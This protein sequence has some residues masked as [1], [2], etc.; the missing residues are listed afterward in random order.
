MGLFDANILLILTHT[1]ESG[2][3]LSRE[4]NDLEFKQS[5]GKKNWSRY[6]RTM[7][8]FAN[9]KGG[10]IV[11]GVTDKN[12]EFIGIDP[13]IG[14][15]TL[16]QEKFTDSLNSLFSPEIL[17][18][19][20]VVTVCGKKA[21]YIYTY[22]S[23]NKPV[24]ATKNDNAANVSTGDILYR[25]RGR[26]EKIK[27]SEIKRIIDER[28]EN[29]RS[30]LLKHFQEIIKA[31]STNVGIVNYDKGVLSTPDGVKLEID[32][33]LV[34]Q[35]LKRAK[36]IKR[37]SFDEVEGSPVLRVSGDLSI[38]EEIEVPELSPDSKYPYLQ[39]E[40][41]EKLNI[42]PYQVYALVWKYDLKGDKRFHAEITTSK[43]GAVQKFS[44][45]A[46]QLIKDRI[47]ENSENPFFLEETTRDFSLSKKG[48]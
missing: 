37:G 19:M 5:Y 4:R 27:H 23:T 18:D 22:E 10:L 13:N 15:D 47:F 14:F 48:R 33:K 29:E 9:N 21:G 32:R 31:G 12:R 42:A 34:T 38:A 44:E 25:Y 11:F 1:D 45:E 39:K 17:W 35:I 41:A 26:S 28:I 16:E 20:G 6:M 7:A 40:L 30:S 36:Y 3:L 43:S 2:K 24:V 46:Y 8:S